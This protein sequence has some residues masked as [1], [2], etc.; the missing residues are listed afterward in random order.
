MFQFTDAG[1]L[2]GIKGNGGVNEMDLDFFKSI[3]S[4]VTLVQDVNPPSL[5]RKG[6]SALGVK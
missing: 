2:K 5:Y 3:D 1:K 4:G 6:D